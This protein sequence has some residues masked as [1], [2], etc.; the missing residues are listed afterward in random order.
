M[1]AGIGWT[2]LI[3]PGIYRENFRID[4]PLTLKRDTGDG[5]VLIV[6]QPGRTVRSLWITFSTKNEDKDADTG[7]LVQVN[8]SNGRALGRFEQHR[9]KRYAKFHNH[10]EHLQLDGPIF[11]TEMQG[12]TLTVDISPNGSD[13]WEFDWQ[14][15][16]TWSDG[17]SFSDQFLD[18]SLDQDQ[19]HYQKILS[20]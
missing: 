17:N 14:L 20:L 18:I 3:R 5:N 4:F 8:A 19:T 12:A 13:A 16:G 7:L 6:G 11:E 1:R 15:D 9:D 2:V 10:T